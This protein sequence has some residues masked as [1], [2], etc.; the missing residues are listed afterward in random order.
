MVKRAGCIKLCLVVGVVLATLAGRAT[1][2][3]S[4]SVDPLGKPTLPA[5]QD[6]LAR[7]NKL[8]TLRE[9]KR[10][11]EEYKAGALLE[12]APVFQYN[13]AQAYRLSGHYKEALWHYDRF[14]KRTAPTGALREAI[15]QFIEEL[16]RELAS[17]ERSGETP[18]PDPPQPPAPAAVQLHERP[19]SP[20]APWYRDNVGWALAGGGF[21]L[22]LA[23]LG[24][25]V[26]AG[27]LDDEAAQ[28]SLESKRASL[29]ESARKHRLTAYVLGGIGVPL[30]TVGGVKLA[31][32][33][34]ADRTVVTA[35]ARF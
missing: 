34:D 7:G 21:A 3:R 2:A 20:P 31:L 24:F 27:S 23:S 29:R 33:S 5:A 17:A 14:V 25:A 18:S 13:L 1:S 22:S 11:I 28:T 16:N 19:R 35:L 9:F 15:A 26:S 30:L 4:Q 6:H 32:V 12:D 8:Y 10:A